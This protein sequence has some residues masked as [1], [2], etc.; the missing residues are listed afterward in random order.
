MWSFQ[1]TAADVLKISDCDL[2]IYVGGE[3]DEWVDDTLQEAA[4]KDMVVVDLL[5][6]LGDSVK[7]EELIEGMQEEE[8]DHGE[9]EIEY[10][11][12]VWLSLKNAAVL[13]N[14]ISDAVQKIDPAHAEAYQKNDCPGFLRDAGSEPDDVRR[15]GGR[16]LRPAEAD[17]GHRSF[18]D[19]QGAGVP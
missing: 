9:G 10:D 7:E 4:N 11:E 3:S 14:N 19:R 8:H 17:H 12:H 18:R 1:P 15:D 13:V 16:R 5:D 2:F 6:V